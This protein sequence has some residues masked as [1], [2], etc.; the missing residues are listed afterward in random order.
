MDTIYAL[1]TPLGGALAIIRI[2]GEKTRPVLDRVFHGNTQTPRYMAYGHIVES[3]AEPCA[4]GDPSGWEGNNVQPKPETAA[5]ESGLRQWEMDC[6]GVHCASFGPART[7]MGDIGGTDDGSEPKIKALDEAMACFFAGP[8][9]YTGEDMA[10]L[11]I[12][13]SPAVAQRVMAL[14]QREGLRAAAPG[15]FSRRAFLNGKMDLSQAEAVMDLIHAESEKSAAAALEQL[16]GV[17]SA[18]IHAIEAGLIAALSGVNAAIDY[19]EE[20]EE[21]VFSSLPMAIRTAREQ[22]AVLIAEG[23]MGRVLREGAK[24][25]IAGRPNVGKSTLLNALLG[26]ERAIVTPSPGT[27]RDILEESLSIEGIPIRLIDTAGLRE[28]ADAAERIGVNRARAAVETADLLL[29]TLDQEMG[30]AERMLLAQTGGKKRMLVLSKADLGQHAAVDTDMECYVVSAVTGE[31]IGA[32]KA[33]IAR[34]LV[35]GVRAEATESP[36]CTNMRHVEALQEADAALAAA[37]SAVD[38]DCFATDLQN[39]LTALGSITGTAT[40]EAVIE[41]IFSRFCVGK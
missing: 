25:V 14:L 6:R 2:S 7:A 33:A 34:A 24:V 39:A 22:I 35:P 23:L 36:L 13:G 32:L 21:D 38:A 5:A 10:E 30:E 17:L 28:A 12:H 9:S 29:I 27:T 31:G 37:Q 1:A 16:Q 19:P 26:Q 40:D 11:Y 41:A 18:R 20:L 3:C 8:H 4:D 15:E